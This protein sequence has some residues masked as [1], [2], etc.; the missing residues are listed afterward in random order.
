MPHLPKS[1]RRAQFADSPCRE[2]SRAFGAVFRLAV[3]HVLWGGS[4]LA[5]VPS[6]V[7]SQDHT[8]GDVIEE[9]VP[10]T[11]V[12][13][14]LV[15]VPGGESLLGSP[16][17]EDGRDSDEG[18]QRLVSLSPFWMTAHEISHDD[19]GPFRSRRLDDHVAVLEPFDADAVTRPS[20]PYEDPS[21]GMAKDDHPSTG[22]TRYSALQYARWLSEKT[23]RLYRLP[24]EAEWEYA[25]RAGSSEAFGSANDSVGLEQSA[26]FE[27]NASGAYHPVGT[28]APNA[29]GLY[30][31]QG[32]VAEWVMDEYA[33]TA[34]QERADGVSDPL[35]GRAGRGRGI[36]RGGAFDD[37]AV[38]LRCAARFPET[39]AWKRRDP[40]FPKSRWWNTDS[41]HVGFRLVSPAR[42]YTEQEIRDYWA[43]LLGSS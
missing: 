3:C 35:A 1:E 6:A 39:A 37:T 19:F 28:L 2:R 32:N 25:C 12:T 20:P 34:Y 4:S 21:H 8:V 31:L 5:F 36:V 23:G 42:T 30:D 33:E 29:W 11:E 22:M 40:Q 14:T 15:F 26:W 17:S 43:E 9:S 18:P 10:G 38:D 7:L 13:L 24:T 16:E 41:P 27:P